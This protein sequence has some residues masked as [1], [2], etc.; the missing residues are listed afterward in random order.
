[1]ADY[2]YLMPMAS[3]RMCVVI[4]SDGRLLYKNWQVC[5]VQTCRFLFLLN[6]FW[7]GA[8][9]LFL[10]KRKEKKEHMGAYFISF[11]FCVFRVQMVVEAEADVVMA[12]VLPGGGL[13]VGRLFAS[14]AIFVV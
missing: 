1:M 6:H 2:L 14:A 5:M 8:T 9:N 10:H 13:L 12:E 3:R 4:A 11:C 7:Q